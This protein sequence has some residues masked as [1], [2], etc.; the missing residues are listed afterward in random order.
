[1][2]TDTL[3]FPAIVNPSCIR[4][5]I[6]GYAAT[7]SANATSLPDLTTDEYADTQLNI[8][9]RKTFDFIEPQLRIAQ[10][11]T[12]LDVGCGMG[13]M[14]T[15]LQEMGY[16]AYG[17]DIPGMHTRWAAI[18]RPASNFFLIDSAVLDLP[19]RSDS[20]DF[21]FSL[22]VIEHIGTSDGRADR[23]PQYHQ[24]RRQWL[25]EVYRAVKPGGH[26]LIAGPNR[27]F[28]ID[29]A[30]GLDSKAN[31]VER[32]LSARVGASVHRTWG[33]YFLWSYVDF[34]RYLDGLPYSMKALSVKNY[35]YYSR[36]PSIVRP[37]VQ[38]YVN[39]LPARLMSTGFNPWTAA[40]ITKESAH[41]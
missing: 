13:T 35:V 25:R 18:G 2:V 6:G 24:I 29:V 3:S 19:F 30:H 4:D 11:R 41:A 32:W 31:A 36:V 20:L 22:G 40:L 8:N 34:D 9:V 12:V 38:T 21:A 23:L 1:M 7:V 28:P 37:V 39:K 5:L 14:V 27:N 16:E 10:A 26:M 33:E 17:V 15:T